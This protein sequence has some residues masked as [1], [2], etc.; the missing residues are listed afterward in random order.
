M[1]SYIRRIF[2]FIGLFG[3]NSFYKGLAFKSDV[4]YQGTS[5]QIC[6]PVLN[7]YSCPAARFACPVGSFQHF[8]VIKS[9]PYF[10]LGFLG[11]IGAVMGRVPCG[12]FCPFGLLQDGLYKIPSYKIKLH[13]SLKYL[14][15]V[16]L[17]GVAMIVVFIT[18]EPWF[19]KLCPAGT[20]E[21]G[22]PLILFSSMSASLKE[23]L[24]GLFYLKFG[25]LALMIL[26]MVFI[27][28]P[29]CR[30]VCPLG[31]IFGPFNKISLLRYSV[32]KSKCKA[33]GCNICYDVC[34]MEIKI[35][36]NPHNLDCIRCTKCITAC[37]YK[38]IESG[39]V[40]GKK[41]D[42]IEPQTA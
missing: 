34:P 20:L 9:I 3:V 32:N 28:R 1:I 2:Q 42:A 38:A 4:I 7:C 26:L 22:L 30:M 18:A 17:I 37:P 15:Y 16:F 5:K 11:V 41:K 24:G 40:F 36:K 14:K 21:A 12:W 19:C 27:K 25:I 23:I 6:M 10:I 33:D 31:A 8:I 39:T 13:Q 35:Y 29:F